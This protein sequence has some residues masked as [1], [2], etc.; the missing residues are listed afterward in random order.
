M[1]AQIDTVIVDLQVSNREA[2]AAVQQATE[3]LAELKQ[4]E[5]ELNKERK[6]GLVTE[7]AY[8]KR[9]TAIREETERAKDSRNQYTKA[10]REN[11]KQE[12][13]YAD[14]LNG[15]RTQLKGLIQEYDNMSKAEREGAKGKEL[16]QHI[17]Q[18]TEELSKAE[19]ETGRFQR[20]VGNYPAA[21]KGFE[22]YLPLLQGGIKG[23][24]AN[25]AAMGKQLLKLLANPIV[26]AVAAAVVVFQK[27]R[28]AI[29][30]NDE[31]STALQKVFAAFK[32]ILDI[33]HKGLD[34]VVT[35]IGKVAEGFSKVVNWVTKLI[36]GLR[37]FA[38]AEQDLVTATDKLEETERK[39]T[40][41]SAKRSA[42]ISELKAKAADK[43]K[44]SAQERIDMLNK[45]AKLEEQDLVEAKAIAKE[46]LR[47]AKE[48]QKVNSDTSDETANNIAQL[49]AAVHRADQAYNEGMRSIVKQTN[50]AIKEIGA[51][52]QQAI[53][54]AEQ[55]RKAAAQRAKTRRD[56]ELKERRA[57]EDAALALVKESVDKEKHL[58]DLNAARQIEDLQKQLKEERDL[59]V[60]AR[61]AIEQQITL[62]RAKA[63]MDREAVDK[64]VAAERAQ[65]QL[66]YERRLAEQGAEQTRQYYDAQ[67][68]AEKNA[69]NR[70]L[71]A[72]RG[73]AE[74]L[75]WIAQLEA[76]KE[77]LTAKNKQASILRI[78][79]KTEEAYKLALEQA[80][81][82]VIAAQNKATEAAKATT[83]AVQ[84]TIDETTE[85]QRSLAST[86]GNIAENFG[87]LF[88][89][90]ASEDARYQDYATAMG[91][92]QLLT[93]TAVSIASAIEGATKAAAATG[94]A[95]PFTLA[96][97]IGEMVATV[98]GAL[99]QARSLMQQ[100]KQTPKYATGGVVHGAGTDTSDSV[101]AQVSNGESILTAKA[102]AMFYD[103]LSAM[104]VAGGG[105][106]FDKRRSDN[107]FATG[108][109]VSTSALM[110][111]R[112]AQQ[113][114][115]AM[116]EAMQG[117]QPVVSVREITSA[118]NKVRIK[119]IISKS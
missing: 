41:D 58:I 91:Y 31:A 114:A 18:V 48:Q 53:K 38:D 30:R 22:K 47:L 118:Q 7:D 54:E 62:I 108:G 116:R 90:L 19:Q 57:A 44:Y 101:T 45:A 42:E 73:N 24:T 104:N 119:E 80:T 16:V 32:P 23:V 77:L 37:E 84:Q 61:R 6:D 109:V 20:Q 78:N 1:G 21:F 17:Q 97:Y 49:E 70:R 63:A 93:S 5:A 110:Q 64:R 10:L 14:S 105:K 82:E 69:Y 88:E 59:T 76:E 4:E 8:I 43:E 86:F 103:Q 102:T 34:A 25:L 92:L 28:D 99:A 85:A 81:A 15:L 9:L 29:K 83:D 66:E 67:A 95:A 50:A 75:A 74:E 36:P 27:L 33:L 87:S 112:Q 113:M 117:L 79:Y 52:E 107:R 46:K 106:P 94:P 35:V 68:L 51:E 72:A 40:V 96:A 3:R 115:D 12:K 89:T 65:R 100:S 2:V 98:V 13:I 11:V 56:N 111:G 39:Y 60:K 71:Q 26:A 55:R